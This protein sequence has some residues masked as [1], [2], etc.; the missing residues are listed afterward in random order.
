MIVYTTKLG[1]IRMRF[2]VPTLGE[3]LDFSCRVTVSDLNEKKTMTS[4]VSKAELEAFAQQIY[5][6]S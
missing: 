3:G 1:S 5:L 4:I 6:W 2:E